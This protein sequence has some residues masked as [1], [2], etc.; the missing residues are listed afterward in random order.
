MYIA[1]IIVIISRP[2][3]RARRAP[4][5]ASCSA[6]GR[7]AAAAAR[8][9]FVKLRS[10]EIRSEAE[11]AKFFQ[12]A[13]FAPVCQT[14]TLQDKIRCQAQSAQFSGLLFLLKRA[15]RLSP[16]PLRPSGQIIVRL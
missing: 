9:P 14:K 13:Q 2:G 16:A 12:L 7:T 4:R 15:A 11:F 5:A 8:P 3:R 1:I 10:F 6:S